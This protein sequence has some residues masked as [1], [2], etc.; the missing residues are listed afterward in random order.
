[1]NGAIALDWAKITSAA[2]RRR[3]RSIGVI[4]HHL[5][6]Q[7]YASSS[8]AIPR[9]ATR[10]SMTRIRFS[11]RAS[12]RLVDDVVAEHEDVHAALHE[13]VERFGRSVDDGLAAEVE[14]GVEHH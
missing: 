7:K 14:R 2:T 5:C 11:L 3:A 13:G 8:P 12:R 1:M 6:C 9:R 10:P 4:H